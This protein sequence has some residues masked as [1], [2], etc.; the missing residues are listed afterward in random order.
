ML[1]LPILSIKLYLAEFT[2]IKLIIDMS[3]IKYSF[4]ARLLHLHSM[5]NKG[6]AI[7]TGKFRTQIVFDTCQDGEVK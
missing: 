3:L 6:M 5:T 4:L 7:S 2:G 1:I